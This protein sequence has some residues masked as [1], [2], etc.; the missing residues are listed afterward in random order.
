M[1][2][3]RKL[4][5]K[6]QSSS[7]HCSLEPSRDLTTNSNYSS[8]A[9]DD[10]PSPASTPSGS[11]QKARSKL[12]RVKSMTFTSIFSSITDSN[13]WSASLLRLHTDDSSSSGP[14]SPGYATPKKHL[15]LHDRTSSGRSRSTKKSPWSSNRRR[16]AL[17]DHGRDQLQSP[18]HERRI[19]STRNTARPQVVE[20][21]TPSLDESISKLAL[22]QE[23]PTTL[24]PAQRQPSALSCCGQVRSSHPETFATCM[25]RRQLQILTLGP[26]ICSLARW[27]RIVIAVIRS[28]KTRFGV[29]QFRVL[30]LSIKNSHVEI[31]RMRYLMP[32]TTVSHCHRTKTSSVDL[33]QTVL[34]S[35]SC[36]RQD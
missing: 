25:W 9:K 24:Y 32:L 26:Q 35:L 14:D 13:R 21:S 18:A 17:P 4:G 23:R 5:S 29:P 36:K 8:V 3:L 15:S 31:F 12:S 11:P 28:M 30:V 22:D 2:A 19:S 7:N 6:L 34:K 10:I 16:A 1:A 27:K 33:R 20:I